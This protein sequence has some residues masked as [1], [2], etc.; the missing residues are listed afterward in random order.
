MEELIVMAKTKTLDRA[1]DKLVK[2][3][4]DALTE[5]MRY[6]SKKA[7]EDIDFKAK[8]CLYEYYD[9]FQPG[10]GVPNIYERTGNLENAFIPY[11][12]ITHNT[13]SNKVKA[14]VGMG[15][16]SLRLEGIYRGSEKWTPV[17]GWW[18]LDNYLKG[19]HPT[20]NGFYDPDLVE[21]IPIYDSVSPEEKMR[22]YL[23]D[24]IDTFD[25]NVWISFIKQL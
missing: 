5:A 17:D 2:N 21:Y 24:Y 18:V 19:I 9:N 12:E 20:T 15:Y 3:Y 23:Q 14:H 4:G 8:S 6:A 13:N 7:R 22:G 11:M 10:E 25:K 16:H 1:I